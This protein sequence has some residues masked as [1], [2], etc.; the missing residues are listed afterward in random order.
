MAMRRIY[1]L[2]AAGCAVILSG[3]AASSDGAFVRRIDLLGMPVADGAWTS[4]AMRTITI[5]PDTRW[6]M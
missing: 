5:T 6:I 4:P 3:C 1:S 2:L